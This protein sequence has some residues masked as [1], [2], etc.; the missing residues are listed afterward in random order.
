MAP[1]LK[2]AAAIAGRPNSFNYGSSV[3]LSDSG[4]AEWTGEGA[5]RRIVTHPHSEFSEIILLGRPRKEGNATK[6]IEAIF[7]AVIV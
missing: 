7:I 2:T 5:R 4:G 6:G 3:G 1:S